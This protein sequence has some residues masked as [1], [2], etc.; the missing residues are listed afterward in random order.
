MHL[1]LCMYIYIYIYNYVCVYLSQSIT[2]TSIDCT[3]GK[4]A[5]PISQSCTMHYDVRALYD[6]EMIICK[7]CVKMVKGVHYMT[8]Q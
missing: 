1:Y 8:Q 3:M 2:D 4:M 6:N 5:Q 7:G